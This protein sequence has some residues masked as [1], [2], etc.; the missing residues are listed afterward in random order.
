MINGTREGPEMSDVLLIDVDSKIPNLA[1]MKISAYHKDHDD[2]VGFHVSDP[3]LVYAS[4]VFTENEHKVD[5]L[6]FWYP[7]AEIRI[8]GSGY[9]I[10][11]KLPNEVEYMKPDYSIYPE[12]DYSMGFTTRG[13]IRSCDFCVVPKKEGNLCRWQ[14]PKNFHDDKFNKIKLLDNNILADKDWFMKVSK[15][16]LDKDIKVDFNQGLDIR[17]LDKDMAQRIADLDHFSTIKFAWDHPNDEEQIKKGIDM[18]KDTGLDIRH[19]VQFYV[20]TNFDTNH[21]DDLYR[22]RKL[23]E[24]GTNPF[25]MQYESGDEFTNHLARWA[26]KKWIFWSVDFQD[27]DRLPTKIKE[28]VKT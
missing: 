16:M 19:K 25:V 1:L 28:E 6:K 18:L 27:Y 5:G 10:S 26:N 15:W 20:L 8:G 12:I 4:V 2:N 14:H 7:D 3:D 11:K 22:C 23:K 17:L 21:E 24:W 13:C 9:D